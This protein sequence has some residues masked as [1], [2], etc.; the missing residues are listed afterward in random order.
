MDDSS[1]NA[2]EFLAQHRKTVEVKNEERR[3]ACDDAVE[4]DEK[5]TSLWNKAWES[6]EKA[7]ENTYSKP[8]D[9][10]TIAALVDAIRRIV[11]LAKGTDYEDRIRLSAERC[12]RLY[13][14]DP[15]GDSFGLSD[16]ADRAAILTVIQATLD[17]TA[18]IE[19]LASGLRVT[20]PF[21]GSSCKSEVEY[22][23]QIMTLQ[24]GS[25]KQTPVVD[26]GGAGLIHDSL[27]RCRER[28]EAAAEKYRVLAVMLV[29]RTELG[30]K[31]EPF[32][33]ENCENQAHHQL[34][35]G[36]GPHCDIRQLFDA[37]GKPAVGKKPFLDAEGK[38]M[39]YG[40]GKPVALYPGAQR[41]YSLY[42]KM[43]QGSDASSYS[44]AID[45]Y[46]DAATELGQLLN[47][48]PEA[49]RQVLWRDWPHGFVKP[50]P[51]GF[52]TNAVF[53][54][55]WQE[56]PAS[57]LSA[58]R[59]AWHENY[60]LKIDDLPRMR[61]SD[62]L[63]MGKFAEL[64][65][66]VGDPPAFW[67]SWIN[68]I[69]RASINA[70]DL[71]ISMLRQTPDEIVS[72]LSPDGI[73]GVRALVLHL[74]VHN[75]PRIHALRFQEGIRNEQGD[76]LAAVAELERLGIVEGKHDSYRQATVYSFDGD[77]VKAIL[78]VLPVAISVEPPVVGGGVETPESKTPAGLSSLSP[79][80]KKAWASW[81]LA[82]SQHAENLIDQQAYDWLNGQ[83]DETFFGDLVGYELP[84]FDTWQRYLREA[85]RATG[86][87]KNL[88]RADRATGVSVAKQS[89]I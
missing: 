11:E 57:R 81:K 23:R 33:P 70:I 25:P 79:A 60:Q 31:A 67:Y 14:R 43:F 87:N 32:W 17:D 38:P 76:A 65:E 62:L 41:T 64:V 56:L 10:E 21:A 77:F 88:P 86:E 5:F 46:N 82:E 16:I 51:A 42:G 59:F 8:G 40:D 13:R 84:A 68:N 19:E 2:T 35:L 80:V 50:K 66:R 6:F 89:E 34:N 75:H 4:W 30:N 20:S 83:P 45:E 44:E 58:E 39:V 69:W 72:Q 71:L 18:S 54:L 63:S 24:A 47:G 37:N 74:Q 15:T 27:T 12:H 53:E 48:L 78:A 22:A 3:Q 26:A 28:L 29:H 55:A 36:G 61:T 52:W 9:P 85:R 1:N 73:A 49:A 7:I